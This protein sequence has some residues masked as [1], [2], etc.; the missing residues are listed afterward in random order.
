[1]VKIGI[2]VEIEI[3]QSALWYALE[4]ASSTY[5][6]SRLVYLILRLI[7]SERLRCLSIIA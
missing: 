6:T 1:M 3:E 5:S 2:E 7:D 4:F